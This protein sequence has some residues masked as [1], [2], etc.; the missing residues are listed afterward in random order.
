[1]YGKGNEGDFVE[2]EKGRAAIWRGGGAD[3]KIQIAIIYLHTGNS[4]G[5]KERQATIKKLLD[6][7]ADFGISLN[8]IMGDFN[9]VMHAEDRFGGEE[10]T[11]TGNS[12]K[13]EAKEF[14]KKCED[15]LPSDWGKP[16][17]R[18]QEFKRLRLLSKVT[19][20]I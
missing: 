5:A 15:K 6:R 12:D 2:V 17:Y 19:F 11:F 18:Y 16:N 7:M 20:E 9:F 10:E 8:I 13:K 4:G 1:M 3:G 14:L